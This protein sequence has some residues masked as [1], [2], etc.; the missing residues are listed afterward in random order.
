MTMGQLTANLLKLLQKHNDDWND[1]ITSSYDHDCNGLISKAQDR[2]LEAFAKANGYADYQ[3]M[4][5]AIEDRTSPKWVHTQGL[6]R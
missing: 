1:P 3:S 6:D 5:A 2:E 4:V